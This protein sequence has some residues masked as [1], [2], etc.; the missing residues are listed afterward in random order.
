MPGIP[1]DRKITQVWV[2]EEG[3]PPEQKA[4]RTGIADS[5]FTEVVEGPVKEGDRV[6]IGIQTPEEQTQ[7]K[8]PPGFDTGPRMR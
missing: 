6:I 3:K 7:K 8:L 5:L 2:L 4:V 1:V